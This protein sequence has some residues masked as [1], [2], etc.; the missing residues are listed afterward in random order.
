[1]AIDDS[2]FRQEQNLC[3]MISSNLSFRCSWSWCKIGLETRAWIYYALLT[4]IKEEIIERG[5]CMNFS[6]TICGVNYAKESEQ[7]HYNVPYTF[8]HC[9]PLMP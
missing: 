5:F 9:F 6:L 1:M 8:F 2:G 7:V 3:Y 4:P